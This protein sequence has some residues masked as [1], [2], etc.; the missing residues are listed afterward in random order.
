M[1]ALAKLPFVQTAYL[2]GIYSNTESPEHIGYLIAVG[3]DP[4]HAERT[5]H[6]VA[7]ALQV[8]CETSSDLPIDLAH[9]D[10]NAGCLPHSSESRLIY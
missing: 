4:R 1:A 6:A 2:A 7:T 10:I 8:V 9:F 5:S 3:G